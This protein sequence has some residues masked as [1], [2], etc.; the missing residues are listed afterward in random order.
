M[1][2]SLV[3]SMKK[4][5][6]KLKLDTCRCG[7][8]QKDHRQVPVMLGVKGTIGPCRK[9]KCKEFGHEKDWDTLRKEMKA[10]LDKEMSR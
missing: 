3:Q 6:R 1:A 5:S 7:H 2:K 9:C 10:M 8:K 4:I